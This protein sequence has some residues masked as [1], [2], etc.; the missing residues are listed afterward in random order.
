MIN[1]LGFDSKHVWLIILT[2]VYTVTLIFKDLSSICRLTLSVP[3]EMC[4][5][6]RFKCMQ[7]S[8]PWPPLT[9]YMAVVL[10]RRIL[11]G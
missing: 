3:R 5:L 4:F 9:G 6:F 10:R 1:V 7:V 8:Y 2:A 11:T